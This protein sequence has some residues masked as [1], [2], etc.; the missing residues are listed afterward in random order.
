VKVSLTPV[1]L[2]HLHAATAGVREAP[3]HEIAGRWAPGRSARLW[4][5]DWACGDCAHGRGRRIA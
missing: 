3:R 1:W 4:G 2:G 5:F